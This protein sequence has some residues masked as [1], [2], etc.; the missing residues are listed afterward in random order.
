MKPF[1][2][3]GSVKPKIFSMN[4]MPFLF[5]SQPFLCE[6]EVFIP[7]NHVWHLHHWVRL[8]RGDRV[9]ISHPHHFFHISSK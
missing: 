3:Q 6:Y 7:L 2:S 4:S 9:K 5:A 8:G 1:V